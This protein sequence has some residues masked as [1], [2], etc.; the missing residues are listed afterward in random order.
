MRQAHE[1]NRMKGLRLEA[2]DFVHLFCPLDPDDQEVAAL[3]TFEATA[4]FVN[5]RN[6][7]YTRGP[8][9]PRRYQEFWVFRR[10]GERWLL[11]A[12]EPTHESDRLRAANNVACLSA[13]QLENAQHS[14]AL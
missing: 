13:E 7:N 2:V 4:Y 9:S 1:I 5:D 8:R 3:I 14:V 12:I 10:Q 6:G 11:D